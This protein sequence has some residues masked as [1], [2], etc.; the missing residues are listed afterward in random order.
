MRGGRDL[1]GWRGAG[2]AA[3]D[4]SCGLPGRLVESGGWVACWREEQVHQE[5]RIESG[6]TLAFTGSRFR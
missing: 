1:G 5:A 4:V 2:I 3:A 6:E